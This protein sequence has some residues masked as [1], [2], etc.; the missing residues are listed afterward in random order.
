MLRVITPLILIIIFVSLNIFS[1][2]K[3]EP[4]DNYPLW[5]VDSDGKRINQ[6]SG[7]CFI[8]KDSGKKVFLVCEDDGRIC[9]L[10]IDENISPPKIEIKELSFSEQVRRYFKV[11]PKIDFEEIYY[12][13]SENRIYIS[14]EGNS[15]SISKQADHVIYEGIYKFEPGKDILFC[16]SILNV[17]KVNIPVEVFQYAVNNVA[18]EGA[19]ITDN[20]LFLGLENI[21]YD[22]NLFSDSTKIY[23]LNKKFNTLKTISM[24][25]YDI[26]TISALFAKNDRELYGICRDKHSLF[27]FT[28]KNNFEVEKFEQT[29]LDL[30][31]PNHN[32]IKDVMGIMPEC[33]AMDDA[34]DIYVAIDPLTEFYA[35][36]FKDRKKLNQEEIFNFKTW[37]SIIYKFKDPFDVSGK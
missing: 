19:C 34:G 35:P 32:E 29:E 7:I 11:F 24:K 17:E 25:S 6:A 33:L 22:W 36:D 16:D 30:P 28:F 13:K 15:N 12:D 37:T 1:I 27:K 4:V 20:C 18:F 31:V 2:E 8:S 3:I 21:A 10:L 14:I 26:P 5:L 23:I 9:K